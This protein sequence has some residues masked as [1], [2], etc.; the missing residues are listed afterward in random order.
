MAQ[1]PPEFS[2]DHADEPN[3]GGSRYF[4]IWAVAACFAAVYLAVVSIRPAILEGILPVA[5]SAAA[6]TAAQTAADIVNI[7]DSIGQLQADVARNQT[8]IAQQSEATRGLVDRVAALEQR[9]HQ[10]NAEPAARSAEPQRTGALQS[11]SGHEEHAFPDGAN[12]FDQPAPSRAA[13]TKTAKTQ[14]AKVLNAPIETGSVEGANAQPAPAAKAKPPAEKVAAA[15]PAEPK[16]KKPV[17]IKLATGSSVDNLRVSWGILSE[18]H[19]D[20]LAPLQARYFNTVDGNG[21]TFELVAGP[22]KT[23]ADAKKVCQSLKAQA[24]DCQVS[25]FGGNSL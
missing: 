8:D 23:T 7:R 22:F 25:T 6:D 17:G 13:E 4:V 24:I 14:Q 1:R 3:T 21:I 2:S 9:D 5:D 15:S 12:M 18:R 16:P 10:S 19:K 20:E 11:N